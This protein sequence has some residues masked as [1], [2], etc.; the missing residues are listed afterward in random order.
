MYTHN[1]PATGAVG[2]LVTS[3]RLLDAFARGGLVEQKKMA[4]FNISWW[5]FLFFP[6][7]VY[8]NTD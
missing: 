4:C 7:K 3:R 5:S 2:I 6:K 8:R 1:G